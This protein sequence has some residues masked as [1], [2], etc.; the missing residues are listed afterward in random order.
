MI[1]G[2]NLKGQVDI[3]TRARPKAVGFSRN[4]SL[5]SGLKVAWECILWWWRLEPDDKSGFYVVQKGRFHK[6]LW[7][8]TRYRILGSQIEIEYLGHKSRKWR[9]RIQIICLGK[10]IWVTE[11]KEKFSSLQ[12]YWGQRC[13]TLLQPNVRILTHR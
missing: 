6:F 10:S 12:S 5:R 4:E 3:E 1:K 13:Q 8:Q 7:I 11:A 9:V 2:K